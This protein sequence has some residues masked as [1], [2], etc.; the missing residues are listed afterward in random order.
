M[1]YQELIGYALI[2]LCVLSLGALCWRLWRRETLVNSDKWWTL[3]LLAL[4]GVGL[5]ALLIVGDTPA[6][7]RT[8]AMHRLYGTADGMVKILYGGIVGIWL[9]AWLR[10]RSERKRR[11]DASVR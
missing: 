4:G 2:G 11:R 9:M 1:I 7:E 6:A 8:E 5:G 10:W 3:C